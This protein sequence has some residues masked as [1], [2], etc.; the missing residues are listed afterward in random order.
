M[1]R[2]PELIDVTSALI[3]GHRTSDLAM[4]E[5]QNAEERD[6]D[7]WAGLFVTADRRFVLRDIIE[8]EGS[9]LAII[10]AV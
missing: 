1:F 3:G 5:V 10:A 2:N 4:K 9:D 7:D 6:A 8:P